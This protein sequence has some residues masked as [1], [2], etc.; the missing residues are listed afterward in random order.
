MGRVLLIPAGA[1]T[2]CYPKLPFRTRIIVEC[3]RDQTAVQGRRF[4]RAHG[5]AQIEPPMRF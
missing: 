4:S 1:G 2:N 5:I 3:S